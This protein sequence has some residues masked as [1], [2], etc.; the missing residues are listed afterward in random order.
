MLW[1]SPRR[2]GSAMNFILQPWQLYFLILAGWV[3]Y[4]QIL[5]M[6]G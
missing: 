2:V 6:V 3:G 5:W 4:N 1:I